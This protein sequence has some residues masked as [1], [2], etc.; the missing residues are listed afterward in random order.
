MRISDWSSDVCSSD[1][2]GDAG[3]HPAQPSP[4]QRAGAGQA[5][6]PAAGP[7]AGAEG[8]G[9]RRWKMRDRKRVV[10]GKSGSVRVD[11][12]GRRI[13]KQQTLHRPEIHRTAVI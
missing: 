4:A 12:G 10:E 11:I 2:A 7:P 13:T 8:R 1:L 6:G 3:K 5:Q 9:R